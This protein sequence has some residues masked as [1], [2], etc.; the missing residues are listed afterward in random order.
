[1]GGRGQR[2]AHV[3][4]GVEHRDQ[5]VAAARV[6]VGRGDLEADPVADPGLGGRLAGPLD[7]P[8]V[9][10]EADKGRPGVGLG[11]DDGGGA[12]AAAHVGDQ[13]AR[14]EPGLDPVQGRDP[15]GDQVAA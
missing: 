8:V 14:L 12:V 10:V 6:G 7:R 1:V 9:I 13:G 2:V 3:V 5:V 15:G 11:H 4:Q